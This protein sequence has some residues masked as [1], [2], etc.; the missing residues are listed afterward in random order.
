MGRD[1]T[2]FVA[3]TRVPVP[4]A[5]LYAWHAAPGA[6]ERLV[7]PW[8]RVEVVAREGT[9]EDGVVVLRLRGVPVRNR[10]VARH[11]D[12]EPGRRFVDEAER[13]PFARWVHEHL[14]EPD[15][16]DAAFLEDRV[17]YRLPLEPVSRWLA[18]ASVARTVRRMFAY[19]HRRTV[20]DL[21]RHAA[22]AAR[23]RL[24]VAVSGASGLLGAALVA[25]LTSG[26]HRVVRLVREG[27]GGAGTARWDPRSGA[28]DVAALDGVDAVVHLAGAGVADR[29]W[30]RARKDELRRSRVE[31]TAALARAVASMPRPPRVLVTASAVGAYGD[32]GDEPL[33]DASPMGEGF[34]ADLARA[35]EAA[36]DPA[37]GAGVRVVAAR[38]GVVLSAAGGALARMRRPFAWGLGGPIGDGRAWTSWVSRDDAVA[39]VHEALFDERWAG[40]VAIVAPE[41]VRA[42]D[43]AHALAG[44]LRRPAWLRVPRVAARVAFGEV[45][46]A[47]LLSSQRV[48]PTRLREL[49]FRWDHPTLSAALAFE[50]GRIEAFPG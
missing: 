35:W 13:G 41:P 21:V 49:G 17:R 38:F 24:T 2:R 9:I 37:R 47:V 34:L 50:L 15:G 26:G 18:G 5:A 20:V 28:V 23:P 3:R 39:A 43:L 22:W 19:R 25:F 29:R 40:P 6:F 42:R 46:D 7:P 16:P 4:A 27:G 48:T 36:A 11:R 32:R 45:A 33:D 14:V 44:V 30:S 8:Q 10:W 31:G 1:D 12:G